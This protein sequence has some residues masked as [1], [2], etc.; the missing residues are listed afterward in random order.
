[1]EREGMHQRWC[2]V[3]LQHVL[4]ESE[5]FGP[6]GNE[7]SNIPAGS[8]TP[9][10]TTELSITPP[11]SENEVSVDQLWLQTFDEYRQGNEKWRADFAADI[12]RVI[13]ESLQQ[14]NGTSREPQ[15][16]ESRRATPRSDT[17]KS[18]SSMDQQTGAPLN[19]QDPESG[20]E[21]RSSGSASWGELEKAWNLET[22]GVGR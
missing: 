13:A 8:Q 20:R 11:R 15:R 21:E 12:Q 9:G 6:R 10:A 3:H 18:R 17:E 1:M 19:G 14:T 22:E 4:L 7:G 16:T 5:N 2:S